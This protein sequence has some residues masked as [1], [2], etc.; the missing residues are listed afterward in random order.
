MLEFFFVI[1]F[2]VMLLFT[3]ISLLG[4]IA[5]LCV[6]VVLMLLVGLFSMVIKL[7]PWLILAVVG[8]WIYRWIQKPQMRRN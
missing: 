1:G 4:V 2:M 3:G 7:L 6:A 8:V 5:A